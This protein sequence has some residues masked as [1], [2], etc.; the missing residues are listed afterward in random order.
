MESDSKKSFGEVVRFLGKLGLGPTIILMNRN[1]G[2]AAT[3]LLD[4]RIQ[5]FGNSDAQQGCF[6]ASMPVTFHDA[7]RLEWVHFRPS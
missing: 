4:N 3:V 1:E 2:F 5:M 6:S 7:P